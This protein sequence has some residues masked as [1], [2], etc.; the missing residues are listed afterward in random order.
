MELKEPSQNNSE[1]INKKEA[2]LSNPAFRRFAGGFEIYQELISRDG[3]QT[4]RDLIFKRMHE[5]YKPRA[6]NED[7]QPDETRKNLK[8]A[9]IELIFST[10]KEC[11]EDKFNINTFAEKI[12][13]PPLYNL[14][15]AEWNH[16]TGEV[17]QP[18]GMIY[19]NE[20][21][22][23]KIDNDTISVHIRPSN[24]E[25]KEINQ[26]RK[27]GRKLLAE[28]LKSGELKAE[29]VIIKSWLLG[30]DREV[31]VRQSFGKDIIIEDI[32]PEDDEYESIQTIAL[33]Y[34]NRALKK[35]LETGEKP[36]VRQIIMTSQEFIQKFG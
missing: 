15:S 32:Q 3:S 13:A 10:F 30:K 24:T 17:E 9:L 31:E 4:D 34:N 26:K 6:D 20:M 11:E 27:E 8:A 1:Q 19:L 25:S 12:S 7:G 16:Q 29:K 5:L 21:Y 22:A 18:S 23:Y 33:Q 35:Y 14:F 36:E 28:K 2:I